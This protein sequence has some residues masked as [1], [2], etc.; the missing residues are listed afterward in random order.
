MTP[1]LNG[2]EGVISSSWGATP[3]SREA[4]GL[5]HG[6]RGGV[7]WPGTDDVVENRGKRGGDGLP[8]ADKGA[9]ADEM[10]QEGL[11]L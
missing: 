9:G 10:Q 7:R 3:S 1:E 2:S 5:V 6:E 11:L 8:E 4:P